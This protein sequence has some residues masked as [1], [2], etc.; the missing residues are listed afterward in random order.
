[1][2]TLHEKITKWQELKTQM[3]DIQNQERA[4]RKEITDFIL[5]DKIE[6]SKTIKFNGSK[7]TATAVLNYSIDKSA[8]EV[9]YSQLTEA[10]LASIEYKPSINASKFRKLSEQSLM[11]EIVSVKPGMSQLKIVSVEDE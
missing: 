10:D 1:M 11:H 8:L 2:Q 6:G 3:E 7:L 9:F 4:I 5:E